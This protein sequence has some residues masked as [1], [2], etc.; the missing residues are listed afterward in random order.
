MLVRV[1]LSLSR[2]QVGPDAYS[3]SVHAEVF[4]NFPAHSC[5]P[6]MVPKARA[7]RTTL[8]TVLRRVDGGV[9]PQVLLDKSVKFRA[10]RD[11]APGSVLSF[12]YEETVRGCRRGGRRR[13]VCVCVCVGGGGG[14][15][16]RMAVHA[17]T[18][19][20]VGPRCAWRG[21]RL[22]VRRGDV[23]AAHRREE[24]SRCRDCRRERGRR[25]CPRF[26]SSHQYNHRALRLPAR[27]R[28]DS[29]D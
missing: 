28:R 22:R 14:G 12:D 1:V 24:V 15:G 9:L 29:R 6:T 13:C 3:V 27:R 4:D 18:R 21:L 16:G 5:A 20:G 26:V 23:Q 11:V 2:V 8:R 19:A 7:L 17:Q 25:R 10:A